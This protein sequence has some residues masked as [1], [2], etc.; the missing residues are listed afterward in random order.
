MGY[1]VVVC[2]RLSDGTKEIIGERTVGKKWSSADLRK[3]ASN[4]VREWSTNL[5]ISKLKKVD[6]LEYMVVKVYTEKVL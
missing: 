6:S 2:A 3:V 4:V 1:R 5:K